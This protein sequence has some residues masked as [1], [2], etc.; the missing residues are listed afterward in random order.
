MRTNIDPDDDLL[1]VAKHLA[2]KREQ[3]S[4]RVLS[5]LAHRGLQPAS[6]LM[7]RPGKVPI[8]PRK[9]AA[10]PVTAQTVKALLESEL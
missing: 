7:T 2:K 3:S 4:G 10:Q 9:P 1:R 6:R 8:L 5:D